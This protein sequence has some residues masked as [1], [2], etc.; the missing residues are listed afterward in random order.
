[1]HNIM[2][3]LR[4]PGSSTVL[5]YC[6]LVHVHVYGS[7]KSRIGRRIGLEDVAVDPPFNSDHEASLEA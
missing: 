7:I 4:A 5:Q 1:M 3:V 2:R 6:R